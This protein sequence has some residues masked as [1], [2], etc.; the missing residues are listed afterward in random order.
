MVFTIVSSVSNFHYFTKRT[1]VFSIVRSV[2]GRAFF[3]Q[4]RA[5]Y[6]SSMLFIK[7]NNKKVNIYIYIYIIFY[8]SLYRL[9]IFLA[10]TKNWILVKLMHIHVMLPKT[11]CVYKFT[12]ANLENL[13][14]D[15]KLYYYG[16]QTNTH[17][18]KTDASPFILILP[19]AIK[20]LGL[21]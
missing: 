12:K 4:G 15:Y 18:K 17:T 9:D 7:L 13:N 5:F 20:N 14:G 16:L 2:I 11:S 1:M 3:L 21:Y 8:F 19:F 6:L 10:I